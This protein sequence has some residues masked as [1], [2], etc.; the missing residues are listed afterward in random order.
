[1]AAALELDHARD[2]LVVHGGE[3]GGAA[4]GLS[5]DVQLH[6]NLADLELPVAKRARTGDPSIDMWEDPAISA[7]FAREF[8]VAIIPERLPDPVTVRA[9]TEQA[10][11]R[12]ADTLDLWN[13]PID[14]DD[15]QA[16]KVIALCV[17]MGI[18]VDY[19]SDVLVAQLL[20][21]ELHEMSSFES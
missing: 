12:L 1:M 21:I 19:R 7:F 16:L 17:D 3:P 14:F 5:E 15:H 4:A 18:N 10:L 2:L 13:D 11:L 20:H 6:A 8:D 9:I